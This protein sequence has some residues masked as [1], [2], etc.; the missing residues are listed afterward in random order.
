[1]KPTQDEPIKEPIEEPVIDPSNE[2]YLNYLDWKH[3][4]EDTFGV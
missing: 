4:L 3:Y 1:M 2:N